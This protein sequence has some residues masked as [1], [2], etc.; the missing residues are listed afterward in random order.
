MQVRALVEASLNNKYK[1]GLNPVPEIMI[2]LIGSVEEFKHQQRL[3]QNTIAKVIKEHK[4]NGITVKIGTMIE[5]PRAALIANEIVMAGAEFFSYGTNDLTQLTYGFSR[6]DIGSYLPTYI[7]QGIVQEDPF[8]VI[9]EKG[10]GHLLTHSL[11]H[12]L[13]HS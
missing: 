12:S 4:E 3:I 10:V 5:V 1:K 7:K 13:T 8:E 11:A 6:D 9:D 2:P